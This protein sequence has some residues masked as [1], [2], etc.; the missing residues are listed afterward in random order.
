MKKQK[1]CNDCRWKDH[2]IN[3]K[4]SKF[5]EK[6]KHK[7]PAFNRITKGQKFISWL[8]TLKK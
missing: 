3:P 4:Y 6:E 5:W 2:C 7:C 1:N 8:Y